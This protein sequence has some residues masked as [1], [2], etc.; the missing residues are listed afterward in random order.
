MKVTKVR[1][2]QTIPH[3]YV[4]YANFKPEF[5][6]QLPNDAT[7]EDVMKAVE[8]AKHLCHEAVTK[9]LEIDKL[10]DIKSSSLRTL[11]QEME[12]FEDL[13]KEIIR[14]TQGWVEK[15]VPVKE[16][17]LPSIANPS[18]EDYIPY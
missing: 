10:R 5:E 12:R 2:G 13:K 4:S 7:E 15:A 18:S 17:E 11:E 3:P 1:Y 14:T 16:E 6:I 9:A 8:Y